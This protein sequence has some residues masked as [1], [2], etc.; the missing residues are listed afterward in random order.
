MDL[1]MKTVKNIKIKLQHYLVELFQ[2][3]FTRKLFYPIHFRIYKFSLYGMGL[4]QTFDFEKN[5]EKVVLKGIISKTSNPV[6]FD[7]GANVGE[8]SK[9]IKNI[10][11]P[12]QIYAFEPHPKTYLILKEQALKNNFIAINQ[13]LGCK[14]E[15]MQ[16][17]DYKT[18]DGSPRASLFREV[19]EIQYNSPS[20]THD[21]SISTI[22]NFMKMNHIEKIHLLKIDTEGN[23]LNVLL[24]AK[25][26][27][28]NNLID[29]IQ[30]EFNYTNIISKVFF[31][32]FNRLLPGFTFYRIVRDGL[33]KLAPL[34][35]FNEIFMYQNIIAI[36]TC[37]TT[38]K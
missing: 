3:I 12:S 26:T 25:E 7:V 34:S 24:G 15:I 30:F 6:I 33:V 29:V 16:L 38:N 5:G 13:G 22:D 4:N 9:A 21:V 36:N 2:T 19:I 1:K 37:R 11:E 23:E 28:E 10:S 17:F 8:Y 32:D 27:L 18:N 20:V 14:E 31:S 35:V